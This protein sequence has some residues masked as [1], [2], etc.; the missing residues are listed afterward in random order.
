MNSFSALRPALRDAVDRLGH[1]APTAAQEGAIP[2]LLDGH[3]VLLCAPTGTGKSL[4][5]LLPLVHALGDAGDGPPRALV[6]APTRELAEQLAATAAALGHGERVVALYGGV[7]DGPQTR[8]LAQSDLVIAT[9]GRLLDL[10]DRGLVDMSCVERLV[11]DEADRLLDDGFAPDLARILAALPARRQT[12]LVSATLPPAVEALARSLLHEPARIWVD[13]EAPP[14]DRITQHV[15]YVRKADKHRLLAHVLD[16]VRRALVFTRTREGADRAVELLASRGHQA[17][18]LHGEKTQAVRRAALEA[19]RDGAVDVLV[20]TDVASR[21]LHVQG[22]EAV[23]LFDLPSEAETYVHRVGRTAR[24]G[25]RGVA[26]CF[27]DPSEHEHLRAIEVLCGRPLQPV[28]NHPFHD[29]AL[30]P[31]PSSG[32]GRPA[33]R[34]PPKRG[35]RRGG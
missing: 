26:H 11:L 19:F 30:L 15:Y 17:V 25:A 16:T 4:A 8:R 31:P 24:A 18:G 13:E 6:I 14:L 1:S 5:F 21:G 34:G 12:A 35:G 20:A 9:P 10:L 29:W 22:L 32:A 2:A 23:V 27:C 7:A 28:V 3:D 33:K